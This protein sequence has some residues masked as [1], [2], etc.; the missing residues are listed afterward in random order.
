MDIQ[1]TPP[2]DPLNSPRLQP[3]ISNQLTHLGAVPPTL[4]SMP[5]KSDLNKFEVLFVSMLAMIKEARKYKPKSM[6]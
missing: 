4:A 5:L 1:I 6:Q 3:P 2:N